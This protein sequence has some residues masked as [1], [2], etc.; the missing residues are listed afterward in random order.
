[1]EVRINILYDEMN[2]DGTRAGDE[3]IRDIQR[4]MGDQTVWEKYKSGWRAI[5]FE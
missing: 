2:E 1:M 5:S 4:R 3:I